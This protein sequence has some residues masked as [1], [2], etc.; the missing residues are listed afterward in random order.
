[1]L[2][3]EMKRTDEFLDL[4]RQLERIGRDTYFPEMGNEPIIGR[5]Q[6]LPLLKEFKEEIDYCRV[7][8]NFLVHNPKV[9]G[10]YPII[11]SEEMV[12]VL[13][14]CVTRLGNPVL[15]MKF[16]VKRENLYTATLDS[17][18]SEVAEYMDSHGFTHVPV[19]D[20]NKLVGVFSDNS[21]YAYVCANRELNINYQSTLRVLETY[22]ALD[23][24]T[25]EYFAFV[26]KNATL[27]E[28]SKL[29]TID[30][31]SM[32]NLAAVFLTEHGNI[33]EKILAMITP[34]SILR[35]APEYF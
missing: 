23:M 21:I 4:Y 32:K 12:N 1:M 19:F 20:K 5:L 25:N 6:A 24:H 9:N 27:Y 3:D 15:A 31:R 29:F 34:Y 17:K 13:R 14:K 33:N 2:M 30:V 28:V 10:V 35:D 11:P 22:L 26:E 8:R 7:V 18:I 16:A